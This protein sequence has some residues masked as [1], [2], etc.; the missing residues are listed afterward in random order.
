MTSSNNTR[1]APRPSWLRPG[2]YP[3]ALLVLPWAFSVCQAAAAS[4]AGDDRNAAA[5]ASIASQKTKST[6]MHMTIGTRRFAITLT[7]GAAARAFAA[8]LPLTLRMDDLNGNEK[9][10]QLPKASPASGTRPGTIRNGDLML[11]G[12]TTLVLFYLTFDSSYEYTR[13][14]RVND[15]DGLAEALRARDVRVTFAMD[16]M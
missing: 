11:F 6:I 5:Q 2:R 7:D 9:H 12:S 8:Q 16:G 1:P 4:T 3:L 13:L 15:P 14:G 10:A